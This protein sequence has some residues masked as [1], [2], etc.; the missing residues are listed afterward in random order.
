MM[1]QW[2]WFA[3]GALAIL[4]VYQQL[5]VYRVRQES[6]KR[7]EL[8]QI[9]TE[10][11][12][13][14]IALV[15]VKG[16]RLY[17]SPAYKRILGYSTAE[18]SETSSFE[19]I[20]PDDRF[21]VLEAAREARSSGVGKKLEYRIRHK[22]GTWRVLESIAGTIR[23]EKGA[24]AKLVIVNRDITERKVAEERAEHNSLHDGLTGLPNR[25]LFLDRLEQL[26]EHSQRNPGRQ[27]AVLFVDLDGFKAF[28][29]TM[30]P[31][32]GDQVIVEISRRLGNCLRDEDTVSRPQEDSPLRNAVL[33]R[34]GG[35]EFTILLEGVGDP[36]NAMRA[37][38]R[39]LASI[40]ALFL[41]EGREVRVSASVGIALSTT[42]HQRA[43]ELLLD[44]N[45]AMRRAKALGGSRCEVFDEAMHTR[46]LHRLKLE[47][48]L[49]EAI[50]KQQFRV[51]Y[52][53]IVQ[54]ETSQI[55]AFEALLRWQHPEQGLISPHKFLAAEDTGLLVSTGQWLIQ[56]ACQQLRAWDKEISGME[57]VTVS[58]NV[59][60]NQLADAQFVTRLESTL[61]ETG[62]DPSRLRLEM[63]E[64]VAAADAK[65]TA[66]VLSQLKRLGV[67]VILD[68]FGTGNSSLSGLRQFPMEALKID[69]SLVGAMQL[70]RG[71]CETVELIILLA[72][73]LK[74]KVIAE[75]I[76]SA[77]QL[78]HLH[79]FG[80][81][82][83]QGYFFSHPVEAK[84]AERLLRERSAVAHAK[85]VGS[86]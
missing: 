30:G 23:D 19:Q 65:V 80:C 15:D 60:A 10:N 43:E 37:G 53:S 45:V 46:A 36:S 64:S 7:E 74:L 12:A 32:V 85:A 22:D 72:H 54:L 77:K 56:E 62:L 21:K 86:K 29:D 84:A 78:D 25:R 50:A 6:K 44:A 34:M 81:D 41:V 9:V 27:H 3:L 76:E 48:E 47:E 28:N 58:V 33:S 11:A 59:S 20:H 26:F 38:Q 71:I 70:D 8:F 24:V 61:R 68:D 1:W 40:A 66:T 39:I 14:M 31:A 35:D 69:R 16:R 52:Q 4:A 55:A 82:M 79:E 49:R 17:N 13:D 83:G 2:N 42:A 63:T 51:Y 73:K 75:G 57:A 67:S 18:L 5:R